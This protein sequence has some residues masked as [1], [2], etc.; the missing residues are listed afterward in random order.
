MAF[1]TP[2]TRPPTRARTSR[3]GWIFAEKVL[4][5]SRISILHPSFRDFKATK[6]DFTH[7]HVEIKIYVLICML[8]FA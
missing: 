4:I 7:S 8:F 5:K 2:K 1:Q 3:G 6:G